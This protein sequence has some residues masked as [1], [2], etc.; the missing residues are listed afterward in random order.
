MRILFIS[1]DLIAGH[2]AYLLT[3]EGHDVRLYIEEEGRRD[4]FHNL[5][6]K[7]FDWKADLT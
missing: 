1:N 5:V 2:L 3:T 7:S 6:T 4:N